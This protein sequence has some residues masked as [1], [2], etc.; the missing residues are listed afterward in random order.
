MRVWEFGAAQRVDYFVANSRY[1]ARRIGK[2]FRRDSTVIYPPVD[3]T[4]GYLSQDIGDYFLSLSRLIGP[5][6][7]DLLI[8]ACNLFERRL[9]VVGTGHDEERLKGLAGPTI[10]FVGY[11]PGAA[12]QDLYAHCRAVLFAAD[13]DFGI[14]PVE[15]H[16]YGR[17]VVAYGHGGSLET[18][19]VGDPSGRADTGVFFAEQ[20]V[21]SV[22]AGILRF[23]QCEDNVDSADIQQHARQF[24]TS[25]FVT[26]MREFV[27]AALQKR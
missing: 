25:V 20:T 27:D 19:R 9:V 10:E 2:Y 7:V 18:V 4:H 13:E 26:Q 11:V 12:L 21:D 6:H 23:E 1:M 24:D 15:V 17:P 22:V 8:K 5:K 14:A 16:S 3:T